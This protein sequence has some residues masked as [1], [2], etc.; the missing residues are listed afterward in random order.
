[1]FRKLPKYS[2]NYFFKQLKS[3]ILF[4]NEKYHIDFEMFFLNRWYNFVVLISGY[5]GN[6]KRYVCQKYIGY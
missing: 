6:S 1:V 3:L 4:L 2:R 5:N